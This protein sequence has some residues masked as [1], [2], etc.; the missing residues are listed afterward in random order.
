MAKRDDE[1]QGFTADDKSL[2]RNGFII[3]KTA[4]SAKAVDAACAK[5]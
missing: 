4:R 1:T 3:E 2:I 5:G